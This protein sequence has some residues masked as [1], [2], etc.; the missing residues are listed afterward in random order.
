MS[1]ASY[2]DPTMPAPT[3]SRRAEYAEATRAAIVDAAR[4]LFARNG[5]FATTVDEIAKQA[6]V[7]PATVYAVTGGK[8]GLMRSLVDLWSQA[9]VV[10]ETLD[11]QAT[12]TDPDELLRNAAAAVRGMRETYGDIMRMVLA[13]APHSASV[14]EDLAVATERYRSALATLAERLHEVGGL[15]RGMTVAEATD[16]LWFYLGYAGYFTLVDDNGWPYPRAENW[17]VEQAAAALR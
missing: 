14:A 5:F 10:A 13:T 8:Q 2:A 1:R 16:V 6:R 17:L 7:A 4:L 9:P 11:R 15:R 3:R 12:L